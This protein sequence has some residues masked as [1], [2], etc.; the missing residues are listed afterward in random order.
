VLA[1][2]LVEAHGGSKPP[3]IGGGSASLPWTLVFDQRIARRAAADRAA[4]RELMVACA[5]TRWAA[6]ATR[7]R[8]AATRARGRRSAG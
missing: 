4:F 6:G 8:S 7:L 5:E 1:F 2:L 3:E